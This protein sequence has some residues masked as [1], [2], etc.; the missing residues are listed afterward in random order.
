MTFTVARFAGAMLAGAFWSFG[1]PASA[2]TSQVFRNAE[3]VAGKVT[4]LGVVSNLKR[5][6]QLGP[7]P[8]VKVVTP[9]KS[10]ALEVRDGKIKTGERTRCPNL[11]V[12]V[13]AIF[14]KAPAKFKGEDQAV[15]EI[16][17]ADGALRTVTVKINVGDRPAAAPKSDT[18]DL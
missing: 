17:N 15:F 3:A 7:A 8:E 6:C 12:S 13:K 16:K 10:G 2:Q 1:S 9:P 14:Y 4:R 18:Q 5:D 11:D